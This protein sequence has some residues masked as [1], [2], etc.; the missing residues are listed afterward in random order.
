MKKTLL[1][2][3]VL[4]ASLGSGAFAQ[5]VPGEVETLADE[6]FFVASPAEIIRLRQK[7]ANQGA[8]IRA[9]LAGEYAEDI[10][11]DVL[12]LDGVFDLALEPGEAAP[13]IY[14]ARYQ[15]TAI[16][17]I[18]A[19]GNHWPIRKISSWLDGLVGIERAV[20]G[21][22]A[23]MGE[24]GDEKGTERGNSSGG[25]DPADPQSGSFTVTSLRHGA[26]G[27]IT[28]YMH[29]LSQPITLILVSKPGLFHREATIRLGT[30]GPNSSYES[31]FRQGVAAGASSNQDLNNVLHGVSPADSER[32]VMDGASGKA[33]SKGEHIYVQ[34]DLAIFSPAVLESTH[35]AG[36]FRAYKLPKTT[37]IMG[38]NTA[39]QTVT[40]R[41]GASPADA[42]LKGK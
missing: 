18:D 34:T 33:W 42:L 35:S 21:T 1:G 38:T 26:V 30:T 10:P 32:L 28:V 36:R 13:R 11:S 6:S 19:H 2:L 3:G 25:I 31:L 14:I 15:S 7:L 27:N 23:L 24:E 9:P 5:Q 4:A 41:L 16:Q 17:V 37:R 40:V 8:A 39:G 12:D 22:S 29:G 20:D